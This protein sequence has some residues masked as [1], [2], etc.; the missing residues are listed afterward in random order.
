[1]AKARADCGT[2]VLSQGEDVPEAA[3]RCFIEAVESGRSARLKET[4]PTT[5]G[6]PIPVT[7]VGDA[8]GRVE[9]TTDSREDSF[10]TQ[11]VLRHTCTGPTMATPPAMEKPWMTF[12][13]CS[14][15]R[16]VR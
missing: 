4:K 16:L 7:Y 12:A 11:V 5:E 10:G 13:N 8:N 9:R 6:D 14:N 15:A 1:M 3:Y 2:Y